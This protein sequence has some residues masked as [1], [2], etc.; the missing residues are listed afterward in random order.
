MPISSHLLFSTALITAILVGVK[1][2]GIVVLTYISL[3]ISDVEHLF[4]CL[5]VPC[6]SSLEKCLFKSLAIVEVS[7]LF[8][9]LLS[10]WR[11]LYILDVNPLVDA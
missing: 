10:Y 3:V 5:L 6:I 1:W 2:Q 4:M 9:L 11:S 8:F 7:C